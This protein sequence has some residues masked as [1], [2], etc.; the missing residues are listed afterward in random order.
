MSILL[1]ACVGCYE[2]AKRAEMRGADRIE[3]EIY[4]KKNPLFN[5]RINA[6][7]FT[8]STCRCCI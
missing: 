5:I 1:E 3:G 8:G 4:E 2:E 7:N 6:D